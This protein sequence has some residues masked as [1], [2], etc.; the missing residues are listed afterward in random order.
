VPAPASTHQDPHLQRHAID[1]HLRRFD[2]ALAHLAAAGPAHFPA[3]LKLAADK[4]L[5]RQLI[6]LMQEQ[7]REA[8]AAGAPGQQ[9]A[10]EQQQ[11]EEGPV[12][13]LQRPGAAGAAARLAAALAAH[14]A[15][16]RASRRYEDAAVAFLA[17]GAPGDALAAYSEGGHWKMALALAGRLGWGAPRVQGLAR[18]LAGALAASGQ[19]ADAAAVLREYVRDVDGAVAALAGAREWREALRVAYAEGRCAARGR[20]WRAAA[21][22]PSR[23]QGALLRTCALP[24]QPLASNPPPLPPFTP[25]P[26]WWT[27]S[28]CRP[29]PRPP[30]RCSPRPRRRATRWGGSGGGGGG[31]SGRRA[32]PEPLTSTNPPCVPSAP[33]HG[34]PPDRTLR[35]AP[36]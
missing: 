21:V 33:P 26:T 6:G 31:R 12:P 22:Q 7:Q 34:P 36:A 29:Q 14:A 27:P 30:R 15:A 35:G 3:A 9:Q 11:Q 24:P 18:E 25:G 23:Q 4:G 19:G 2:R 10:Q 20:S 17:A 13:P 28:S 32:S 5:L 16:L 8:A 1:T